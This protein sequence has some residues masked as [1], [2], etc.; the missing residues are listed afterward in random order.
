MKNRSVVLLFVLSL[1]MLATQSCSLSR[2]V[3][4]DPQNVDLTKVALEAF[5]TN[6]AELLNP[7]VDPTKLVL[8]LQAT[9]AASDQQ[10]QAI[11]ETQKAMA[12]T[13][14][15]L[16]Q[17]PLLSTPQAETPSTEAPQPTPTTDLNDKIK[18]AKILV[19]ED[20]QDIGL[21]V[22]DA[23]DGMDVE[24]VFVG[25]HIGTLM[26][27]LNSPIKW[28]LIIIAAESKS[29]VQGEFWDMIN[30]KITQDKTALIAEVWY[31]DS[32]GGGRIRNLLTNCGVQFQAD[33]PL[34]ESIYWL[35]ESHP[36]F[37]EPNIAMP[38]IH[39]SRH[40]DVQAGDYVRLSAGST[41]DLVGGAYLKHKS[42]YG[43]ITS[44][45]DGRVILQTFSNHDFHKDEVVRLWQ[46]YVTF[47]LKNH[48]L[49]LP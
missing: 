23:L 2:L 1:M 42:D 49:A 29:T 5:A 10:Q 15:V 9:Q 22:S 46:N 21:W 48:F 18:N 26:E 28:D 6:Q 31:L 35:D 38:L 45:M 4:G 20:T 32:L 33:Y 24:Y 12:A 25:D 40:W 36:L 17:S 3:G 47:T 13:Q 34:A 41:A 27:N 30:E 44:C 19:Y 39:Y 11:A 16:A 14:E 7:A 37:Q 8:E 43:L